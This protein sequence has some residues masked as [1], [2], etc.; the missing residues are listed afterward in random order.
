[1]IYE[2]EG[3]ILMSRAD[4]IAQGV[5]AKAPMNKWTRQKIAGEISERATNS[6]NG[7]RIRTRSPATYGSGEATQRQRS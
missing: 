6:L 5:S 3:D 4:V 1:M 2:V 7:A